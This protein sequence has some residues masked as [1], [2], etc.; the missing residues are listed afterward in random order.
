MLILEFPIHFQ[1]ALLHVGAIL[2]PLPFRSLLLAPF[3]PW[4]WR[5]VKLRLDGW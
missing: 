4:A 5:R 3:F 1:K 2:L